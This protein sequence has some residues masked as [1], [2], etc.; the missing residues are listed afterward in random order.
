VF[1]ENSGLEV[2]GMAA[3]SPKT[4]I[5]AFKVEKE[6]ADL[7]DKLPNK[8]EFIRKAIAAQLGVTCPLCL[9]KGVIP[10][11]LSD[12]FSPIIDASRTAVCTGCQ[13][14]TPLPVDSSTLAS[15]DQERL[16]QFFLGGPLLCPTCY[17]KT[18]TCDDCGWHLTPDQVANHNMHAH[19]AG[20][21]S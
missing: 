2:R 13:T 20:R 12:H 21:I 17:E 6:L 19:P 18:L 16:D 3:R 14:S 4:A 1:L 11:G 15:S 10:R 8:S 7:L 9:G 5:V